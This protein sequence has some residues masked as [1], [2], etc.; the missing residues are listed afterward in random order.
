[1]RVNLCAGLHTANESSERDT[2]LHIAVSLRRG[3]FKV[4]MDM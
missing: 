1:V 4:W 3:Q 2:L